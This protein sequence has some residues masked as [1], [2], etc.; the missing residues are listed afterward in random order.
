[1]S[2]WGQ[3]GKETIEDEV[4]GRY[5]RLNGHDFEHIPVKRKEDTT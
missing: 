5:G 1:M 3:E 4:V 2:V